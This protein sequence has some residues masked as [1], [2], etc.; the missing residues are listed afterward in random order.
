MSTQGATLI[1]PTEELT[2]ELLAMAEEYQATGDDRYKLAIEDFTAYFRSLMK[3]AKGVDLPLGHVPSSTFWLISGS[4]R[5]IGRSSLR[6]H[7][8][9]ELEHEG[10]HIGYDIRPS[11][12]RK[13]YGTL[14]LK[15]TLERA[16]DI[17]LTRVFI[18]CDT[19]NGGSAK[20]IEKNGGEMQGQAISNRTGK[21]IS[22]YWIEL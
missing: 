6:H 17:G 22:Q 14:T 4:S 7:L 13:G 11:E 21:Q 5:I 19:D 8:T 3:Y 9:T 15:L 2:A 10:G 1:E 12:R 18:T 16:R 20:V